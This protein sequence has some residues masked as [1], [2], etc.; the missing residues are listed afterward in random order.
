MFPDAFGPLADERDGVSRRRFVQ[1]LLAGGAVATLGWP[2]F[3]HAQAVGNPNALS[4]TQFDLTIGE[5]PM[6]SSCK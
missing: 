2:R 1:G 3:G 5:T 6:T 4:G